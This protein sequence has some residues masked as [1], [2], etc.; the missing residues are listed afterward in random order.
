M[1]HPT[2]F[3]DQ[4]SIAVAVVHAIEWLKATKKFPWLTANTDKLNRVVAFAVAFLTSVG[5]MFALQ[6]N[7]HSGGTLTITFPSWQVMGE[8]FLRACAQ[9]GIQQVYYHLGVKGGGDT[10]PAP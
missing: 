10:P 8:A 1:D 2:A 7:M 5:F 9:G 4:A 6:G 3:L